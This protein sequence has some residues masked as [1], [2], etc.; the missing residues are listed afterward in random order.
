VL[1]QP[2]GLRDKISEPFLT[3]RLVRVLPDWLLLTKK[4][5]EI[6][7]VRI[8][9]ARLTLPIE[10]LSGIAQPGAVG[11][12]PDT[13]AMTTPARETDR[14]LTSNPTEIQS[15]E[16]QVNRKSPAPAV[17]RKPSPAVIESDELSDSAVWIHCSDASLTVVSSLMENPLYEIQRIDGKIPVSG[18]PTESNIQLQGINSFGSKILESLVIP[19]SW[20]EGVLSAQRFKTELGGVT[21]EFKAGIA[22]SG[23]MPFSLEALVPSQ[24]DTSIKLSQKLSF[25]L[26]E[27]AAKGIFQGYLR[28]PNTWQGQWIAQASHIE[29]HFWQQADLFQQ[30]HAHFIYQKGMLRCVDA[31]LIGSSLSVLANAAVIQDGRLSATVRFVSTPER[32][33]ALSSFT[34]PENSAPHFTP[35][36][37][38]QRS[39]LDLQIYGTLYDLK[40]KPDPMSEPISLKPR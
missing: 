14:K 28:A 11:V 17:P 15:H 2:E 9:G 25:D 38:P 35:L 20:K 40:Y 21:C 1:Q 4:Q 8:D 10:I 5:I 26:R 18:K 33:K 27:I 36:H 31:R 23:G 3:I 16:P 13:T 32:L 7:E 6:E 12:P 22:L 19:L 37:T 39:A 30:G 34:H 29:A 24:K